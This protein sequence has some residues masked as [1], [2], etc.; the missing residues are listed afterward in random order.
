METGHHKVADV[1]KFAKSRGVKKLVFNHHGREI[2]RSIP[3]A[4]KVIED[5]GVNGSIAN[6]GDV[7]EM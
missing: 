4:E 1:C 5:S 3:D 7:I 6:D 2:L